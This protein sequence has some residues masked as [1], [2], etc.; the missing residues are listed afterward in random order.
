MNNDL[1]GSFQASKIGK[2][3]EKQIKL[4]ADIHKFKKICFYGGANDMS[5]NNSS[6]GCYT[7]TPDE[8]ASRTIALFKSLNTLNPE[9]KFVYI[10]PSPRRDLPEANR[11][12][13]FKLVQEK[14]KSSGIMNKMEFHF[15]AFNDWPTTRK[16]I[17]TA[18]YAAGPS[19]IFHAL[20]KE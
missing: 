13:V 4:Q 1:R 9:A 14:F 19:K 16:G 18:S 8:C 20:T 3:F 15:L 7:M 17:H 6:R 5:L 12:M 10:S 2:N 11:R